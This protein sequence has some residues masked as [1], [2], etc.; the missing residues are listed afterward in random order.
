MLRGINRQNIFENP[1]DYE[2][3][4]LCLEKVKEGSGLRIFGYCLMNNHVHIVAG[5]G[6]ESIGDSMKRIG[7]RYASWYNRKYNRQGALFQD[8]YRSEPIEDD[9]YLLSVVRYIHQNPKNAGICKTIGDHKWSS[10]FDYLG[11]GDG[12]T[13]TETVLGL[14]S[15]NAS[16][17]IRLFKEFTAEPGKEV[18]ADINDALFISDDAVRGKI[19]EICG[20]KSVAGFQALP[21]E[22]RDRAIRLM[23]NFG[24]SIRQIVRNTGTPFGIVRGIGSG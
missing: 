3:F 11:K 12:L 21:R 20:A 5:A 9:R 22:E 19:I 13:D 1:E 2:R 15:E 18:F 17:R 4:K 24:I 6:S 23:R 14:Y 8:R 16:D 10:Y 7:V